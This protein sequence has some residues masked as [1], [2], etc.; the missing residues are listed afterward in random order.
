M[1]QDIQFRQALESDYTQLCDLAAELDACHIAELPDIFKPSEGK[2]RDQSFFFPPL[3]EIQA[4]TY[5]AERENALLG[6]ISQGTKISAPIPL[7]VP[8]KITVIDSLY[9]TPSARRQGIAQALMGMAVQW[10]KTTHCSAIEL[11]VYA[12][13]EA[14]YQFYRNEGFE[15]LSQKLIL[16]LG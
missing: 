9:V 8:R 2:A 1:S 4:I 5:V 10:A 12:F 3:E 16:R 14:A 15:T 13:N 11:T 6:F 7:L